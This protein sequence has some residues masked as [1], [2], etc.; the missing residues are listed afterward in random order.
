MPVKAILFDLEGTIID[1][2][3]LWDECAVEFLGRHGHT[4]DKS[5]TKHLMMGRTLEQGAVI[6]REHHGFTGN[7]R[8]LAQERREI[9]GQLLSKDV[10]F[11][12]GFEAFFDSLGGTYKVAIATSMERPFLA[13]TQKH[14]HL[15]RFFSHHI[16]SIADIGFIAKPHPDIFLYAAAQ[17]GT[18]PKDCLV[19]EDAPN[20]VLAAK[21]A[22]MYCVAITTSTTRE[23]LI[24]AG[25][26]QV[27]DRYEEIKL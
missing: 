11:I 6:L 5:A 18:A 8:E 20:G 16:Y 2:E 22:G 24:S 9:F 3:K 26:D 17:L 10:A 27:V 23:R 7:P 21:A 15:E 13:K 1:T 12:P 19:I 25:A 4:Y 14:L